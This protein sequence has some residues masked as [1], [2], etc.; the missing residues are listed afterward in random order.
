M[1]TLTDE[2]K[3][4]ALGIKVYLHPSSPEGRYLGSVAIYGKVPNVVRVVAAMAELGKVSPFLLKTLTREISVKAERR[5]GEV[6]LNVCLKNGKK[7]L[8]RIFFSPA[9]DGVKAEILTGGDEQAISYEDKCEI[10][11]RAIDGALEKPPNFPR[12]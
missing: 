10:V 1:E 9:E 5:E 6:N 12:K 3:I 8:P 7:I 11:T 2:Q 4:N